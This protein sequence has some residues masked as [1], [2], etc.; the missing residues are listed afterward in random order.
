[1]MVTWLQNEG[2]AALRP[3]RDTTFLAVSAIRA[4]STL[5]ATSS[6]RSSTYQ[7][8]GRRREE[9]KNREEEEEEEG[10]ECGL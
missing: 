5:L 3:E 8:K 9:K 1:M 4:T 6:I 7:Y 2:E 10:L